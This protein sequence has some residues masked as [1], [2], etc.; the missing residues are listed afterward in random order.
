M[1]PTMS[2]QQLIIRRKIITYILGF[3]TLSILLIYSLNTLY[4][5]YNNDI[6]SE[7]ANRQLIAARALADKLTDNIDAS[8]DNMDEVAEFASPRAN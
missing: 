3:I 4:V 5:H 7:V 2:F 6:T 1:V 8:V